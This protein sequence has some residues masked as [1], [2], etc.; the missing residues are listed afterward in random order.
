ME[1]Q[2]IGGSKMI[3]EELKALGIKERQ[4][5]KETLSRQRFD[6]PVQIEALEAIG[7]G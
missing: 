2:R 5:Q 4:F 3:E 1:A 7:R 6:R